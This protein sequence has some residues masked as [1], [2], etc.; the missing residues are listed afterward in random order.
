MQKI[1]TNTK[2]PIQVTNKT[3]YTKKSKITSISGDVE[4]GKNTSKRMSIASNEVYSPYSL[5]GK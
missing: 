4:Y 1:N 5:D 3:N 2:A